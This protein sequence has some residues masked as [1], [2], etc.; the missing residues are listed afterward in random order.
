MLHLHQIL[1]DRREN[2]LRLAELRVKQNELELVRVRETDKSAVMSWWQVGLLWHCVVGG[3]PAH[4]DVDLDPPFGLPYPQDAKDTLVRQEYES[5]SRKKRKLDKDKADYESIRPPPRTL[6]PK[7][8]TKQDADDRMFAW[9]SGPTIS[10]LAN[11][12]IRDD[13]AQIGVSL[14]S[15]VQNDR[16]NTLTKF[17]PKSM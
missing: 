9:E 17:F 15:R 16:T 5:N 13:L 14:G 3:F 4:V 10:T 8:A 1:Q 11:E 7:L 6:P 2:L 12:E